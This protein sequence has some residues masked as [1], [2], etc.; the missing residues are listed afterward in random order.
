MGNFKQWWHGVVTGFGDVL[1]GLAV[2]LG[3]VAVVAVC[4][5]LRR[6][7]REHKADTL[8]AAAAAAEARL[9]AEKG[10][11]GGG[12]GARRP[13]RPVLEGGLALEAL[14]GRRVVPL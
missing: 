5:F 3:V 1:I 12:G 13:H 2:L 6:K 10:L 4:L 11:T 14:G 8:E 9:A 7:F